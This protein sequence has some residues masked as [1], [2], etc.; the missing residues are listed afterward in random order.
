MNEMPEMNPMQQKVDA[1]GLS[2]FYS[3]VYAF[4]AMGI[5]L[6]GAVA[7]LAMNVFPSQTMAFVQGFPLG[8]M[9]IWLV[10]IAL[11]VML[12]VKA[13]KNP[14]LAVGGFIAY[15]MINGLVLAFTLAYYTEGS[16]ARAFVTAGGMFIGLSVFGVLTKKDLSGIGRAAY[17]ALI[18]IIIAILLNGFILQSQPVD[19]L[20]SILTIII[21]SGIT[22]YDNQNIR[23]LY[24]ASNGQAGNG[25]AVFMALQLYL[26]FINLFLAI[27]RIF[28]EKN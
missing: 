6:S 8:F 23:N 9:G 7:Y 18:G 1:T 22:A 13:E 27:L 26:D 2:R 3:K 28:G 20:I 16:V 15:S 24:V 21:F 17:S 4:L 11:V 14:S 12:G 5:L 19:Y 25:I 10:E